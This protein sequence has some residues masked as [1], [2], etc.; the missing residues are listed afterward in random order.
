[1]VAIPTGIISAGFVD[2]YSSIKKRTE[3]GYEED[4]HFIKVHLEE[5]DRWIGNR[6]FELEL[7]RDMIVAAVKR[8]ERI[9]IP[10]GDTLLQV[11]DTV[12][13]GAEPFAEQEHINLKEIVLKKQNP[14]TGMRIRDLDISRHSVIVLV[15]R[16][17]KALIP[18]GNLVLLEWDHVFL[19]TKL[20]LTSAHDIEI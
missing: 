5:N 15:K 13:L 3:Y 2:Q 14:W 9:I 16:K 19:Y 17:N 18:N 8:K 20:H 1:M 6:I 7:P 10:R 4:M 12:I 11:N